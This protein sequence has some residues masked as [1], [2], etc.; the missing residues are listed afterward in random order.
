MAAE[1]DRLRL[2]ALARSPF[3]SAR[4]RILVAG[5]SDAPLRALELGDLEAICGRRLRDA[6]WDPLELEREAERDSRWMERAGVRAVSYFDGDYPPL[7][8]ETARP[9]FMLYARGRLPDP[10]R[11][12]LAV[13]GT[14]YPTGRGLSVAA[15]IARE[16][17]R[18]GVPVVSGLARGVDGAAH[19]G[20]LD[21]AGQTVAVL[22]RGID[23]VYPPS[24]R[25]LARR[26]LEAGGGLVSEYPPGIGPTR[27]TFPERNR[28]IAGLCR[29]ALVVEAPT[30]SG[31]LI[32][33]GFALEEGRDVYVAEACLG[34][35]RSAGADALAADGARAV[36]SFDEIFADWAGLACPAAYTGQGV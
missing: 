21:G 27:W 18:G 36:L 15:A 3:L 5:A 34:G 19:R 6:R 24:H 1:R 2:L 11:P 7:L 35:P 26:I 17:A 30:G 8:R 25:E 9:P 29:A 4:E 32:T 33:A 14:R 23:G 28:I 20:A 31:A 10:E 12:A 13:V 16:A 22:G